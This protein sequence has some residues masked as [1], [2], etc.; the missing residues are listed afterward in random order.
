MFVK[1]LFVYVNILHINVSVGTQPTQAEGG[2][3]PTGRGVS[4][5]A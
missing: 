1:C 2:T 3:Y 5:T 4:H